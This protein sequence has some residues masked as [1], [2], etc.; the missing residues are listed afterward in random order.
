MNP[1]LVALDYPELERAMAMAR[2][3]REHVG[4]FKVG[5][6][7]MMSE[8]PSAIARVADL[9]L[10]VFADAKL[11][12]IP[13]Q[14]RAA[15]SALAS[16]GAR[17]VTA[18]ATGGAAMMTAAVEGLSAGAGGGDVGVLA[19]TVLTS[20]DEADLDSV[21]LAGPIANRAAALAEL[22]A[23]SGAEGYVCSPREVASVKSAVPN[24]MAVTPG[25]RTGTDDSHDQK[26]FATPE[27]SLGAGADLLV[28]GRAITG[29]PDPTAAAAA[30]EESIRWME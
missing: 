18:H 23:G 7:L 5:L 20:L 25:I 2:A 10:P 6:R 30:I 3:T 29:A 17:W 14:V 28:V 16:H 19:V 22:A 21:G 11:H 27:A 1:I 12:D 4:G 9:G 15:A 26:R 24:L 8:G 13:D